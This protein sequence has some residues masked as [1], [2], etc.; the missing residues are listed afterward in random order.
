MTRHL[1][2]DLDPVALLV[3]I[4]A[5]PGASLTPELVARATGLSDAFD[6]IHDHLDAAHMVDEGILTPLAAAIGRLARQQRQ[7]TP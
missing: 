4:E 7:K 1:Y 6:A 2:P 5:E 3:L